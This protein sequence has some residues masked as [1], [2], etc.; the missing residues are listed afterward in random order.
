MRYRVAHRRAAKQSG[1]TQVLGATG[2]ITVLE[3][4]SGF[5]AALKA[6]TPQI[7]LGIALACAVLIFGPSALIASFGLDP[8]LE[9]N[10]PLVGAT[11][12]GSCSVLLAQAI[13]WVAKHA[14]WPINAALE[15]RRRIDVLRD[16][17]ADE[18]AYLVRYIAEQRT[19]Q[20][21]RI[22]DGV[23]QGLAL[24]TI[25]FQSASVGYMHDGWAFNLNTWAR[26][27]LNKEPSLLAGAAELPEELVGGAT[28]W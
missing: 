7:L 2:E 8:F 22:D 14:A 15:Y 9:A 17:A 27:A 19:T 18:K 5:L 28:S 13:W 24:K 4:I 12:L 20:Y 21:F 10:R 23:A 1:L 11:L 25:I 3:S 16:L 6:A 26:R